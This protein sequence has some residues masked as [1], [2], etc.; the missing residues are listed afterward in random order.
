[1]SG[2]S[3]EYEVRNEDASWS[4]MPPPA[5][6]AVHSRSGICLLPAVPRTSAPQPSERLLQSQ[7]S[8]RQGFMSCRPE[9]SP[10]NA[11]SVEVTGST[12]QKNPCLYFFL[13]VC[14]VFSSSLNVGCLATSD[15]TAF[16]PL[17]VL[18]HTRTFVSS[19]AR[20]PASSCDL[21]STF[22]GSLLLV[23]PSIECLL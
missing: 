16:S 22:S 4:V 6:S 12:V 1:L 11:C 2:C 19:L 7:N 21:L 14:V 5:A 15:S 10:I 9:F 23:V 18:H 8:Q 17:S 20:S 13:V 3:S